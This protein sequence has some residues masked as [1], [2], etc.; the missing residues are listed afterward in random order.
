MNGKPAPGSRQG[1]RNLGGGPGG[2]AECWA[3]AK[4]SGFTFMYT[5]N[6]LTQ[7]GVRAQ[8][9]KTKTQVK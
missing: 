8:L 1:S 7:K 3:Y 5:F 6:G 4:H 9:K 2:Q